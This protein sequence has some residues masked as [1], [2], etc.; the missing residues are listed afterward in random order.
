[1]TAN[2]VI[3]D[4]INYVTE[5]LICSFNDFIQRHTDDKKSLEYH[6]SSELDYCI[7]SALK[8][9]KIMH[10]ILKLKENHLTECIYALSR[11]IFENYM[12]I[13]NII[14]DDSLFKLKMSPKV[15]EI[16]YTF[17]NHP[18]GSINFNK[19]INKKNWRKNYD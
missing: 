11:G 6:M 14:K 18:D 9:L 17:D 13:C 2:A 3:E 12:Y 15:D 4:Q 1:M 10:S 16:N 8:T 7:F 19:V 5:A